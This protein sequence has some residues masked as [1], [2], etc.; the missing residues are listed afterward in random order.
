MAP[1][2]AS[3]LNNFLLSP[4]PLPTIISL[5]KFADLFPKS[6]R[7][8]P[9][10]KLLYRELQHLRA[11]DIDLVKDNIFREV[12]R[13]DRQRVEL[14]RA[15]V[16]SGKEHDESLDHR[17][18]DMD[19]QLFGS[20]SNLPRTQSH[21]LASIL[22]DMERACSDIEAEVAAMDLEAERIQ[23]GLNATVGE[24]S[25]LRYGRLNKPAGVGG[26]VAEEVVDGLRRLE[27]ACHPVGN[28]PE[29]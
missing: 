13:G 5:Q 2:E 10:V 25:D 14:Q 15:Q 16:A 29:P 9:Q 21:D 26:N 1:T 28:S 3:I 17:E 24:L 20:T 8:H 19:I 23:L 4:A 27:K 11:I 12:R 6:Q 7:S 18:I 22:P